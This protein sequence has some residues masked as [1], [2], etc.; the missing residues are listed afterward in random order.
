MFLCEV[1]CGKIY[2][3]RNANTF[4]AEGG[5]GVP[6]YNCLMFDGGFGDCSRI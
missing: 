2:V 6:G 3:S 5:R 1:Q 4:R